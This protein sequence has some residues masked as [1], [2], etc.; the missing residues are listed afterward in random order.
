MGIVAGEAICGSEPTTTTKRP[1]TTTTS[2]QNDCFDY[3]T[4]IGGAILNGEN[5]DHF[6]TAELCQA[7]L[8]LGLQIKVAISQGAAKRPKKCKIK[9][10][11]ITLSHRVIK[12]H[13]FLLLFQFLF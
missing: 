9:N 8:M 2:G 5:Q 11:K 10:S 4:D 13:I 3:D 12:C 6:S 1:P 7:Y